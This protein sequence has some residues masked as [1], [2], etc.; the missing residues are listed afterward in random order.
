MQFDRSKLQ[1][2]ILRA[3]TTCDPSRLGAVKLHKILYFSDMLQFAKSGSPI[4]GSTYR[5]RPHG[6]TCDELLPIL[7]ELE[8]S[9]KLAVHEVEYFGYLKK[10]YVAKVA[11]ELERL[12]KDEL[13]LIDEMI[14]FVCNKNTAKTISEFSHTRAWEMAELGEILP[15]PSVFFIFPTQ[16]SVEALE[17]A[18]EEA[19]KIET[20]RS[21]QDAV[22]FIDF[23]AFRS[24]ISAPQ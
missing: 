14:D 13:A 22:G 16:A 18:E 7:R 21:D 8:R 17:W 6:P 11:P 4:T 10:E 12:S 23:G 20:P 3:C 1:A 2:L 24:R 5:K 19:K 15:Y 9:G